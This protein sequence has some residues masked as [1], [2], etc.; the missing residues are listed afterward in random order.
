MSAP[1]QLNLLAGWVGMLLGFISGMGLG[2]FFHHEQW[3]G[4]YGSFK[5]RLYRLGHIS[6][7]GLGFANFC[8][9]FTARDFAPSTPGLAIASWAF[10]VGATTM[11]ICCLVT[12]H[13]P[14]ARPFFS[15]PV[16]SL[17]LA[18]IVT[19]LGIAG[20]GGRGPA[21]SPASA[22]VAEP[23]VGPENHPL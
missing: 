15:V 6:F 20:V 22:T 12:A 10:V 16:L 21:V 5:R 1:F 7:F 23:Q 17:I 14:P 4:G 9:Y 19:V 2:M 8:F 11:P 13:H 18:G 3:L